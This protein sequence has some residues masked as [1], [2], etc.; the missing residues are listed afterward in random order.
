[1]WCGIVQKHRIYNKRKT[2]PSFADRCKYTRGKEGK[3]TPLVKK[4]RCANISASKCLAPPLTVMQHKL[5][6]SLRLLYVFT[7]SETP[8]A[9]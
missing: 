2:T 7:L 4:R 8:I 1:M 6:V 9:S 3:G 5:P